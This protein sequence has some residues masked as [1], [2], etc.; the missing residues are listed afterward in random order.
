MTVTDRT[1]AVTDHWE[2]DLAGTWACRL[3][4][5]GVGELE[6]W[7][8][9]PLAAE[10]AVSLP[11][12][13]QEQ[14][15]GDEITLDTPWTGSVADRSLVE[16]DRYAPYREPGNISIPFWLQ[17]RVYYRGAAWY[18]R[19]IDVPAD[20]SDRSVVLHLERVHWESTVW[21]DERRVGQ[22]QSLT[23]PHTHDL[24]RLTPGRHLI[25]LRVDNRMVVDVG[26]NA[27]S[28]TDHTQGNWNGVVGSLTL[29]AVPAVR[30][31]RVRVFPDHA[32]RLVTAK[33]D[34]AAGPAGAGVG[35]VRVH[36]RGLGDDGAGTDPVVVAFDEDYGE[37]L[38][39]RGLTAAGG[40][41][42]VEVPLGPAARTWDEF[43][44]HLYELEV[45]IVTTV[46]GR[47]HRDRTTTVFGLR[48]IGTDGRHLLIN[49]RKSFIRGTLESCVFPLTGYPPTDVASW[50][51]IIDVCR[52]HGLNLLRFHS[53]CPPEAAF[54]AA[55][56]AGF[57]FQIEG[58]VWANQGAGLG[59]ARPVDD[60]VHTETG[61]ILDT[62]G[63]HPSFIMMAHGN[64]PG[65]RDAEFLTAWLQRWRAYDGRRLYT[66][67]AGWPVLE[68]N[69]F[70]ND[71]EPRAHRWGEGLSS[72]L[73]GTAPET[74][75][76]YADRVVRS[77]RPVISHEIGQWCVYP[78]FGEVDSYTGLMQPRNF[79]I[80]ADFLA[81]N[82][83]ADQAED[84]LRASGRL[85]VLCYKEEI[86]SA[87]RTEG[88]GGFHLLGLSDF[89]GQGT[90]LV[91]VVD[92]FWRSKAYCSPAE[93]AR[94]CG[95][96]VP[97]AR[98]PRRVLA[99]T[100]GIELE[101]QVAHFGAEPIRA[102]IAW[103]LRDPSGAE[104][105]SGVLVT[106]AA[107]E[108]GNHNRWGTTTLP[109]PAG[110]GEDTAPAQYS[111]ALAVQT[112][113][114]Q[115]FENDWDIWVMPEETD[116]STAVEHSIHV[117]DDPR[118]AIERAE[119]GADVLLQVRPADIG[120]DVALGFTTVF[121]NTAWTHG[122]APHTLG[123]L[124]D[125][126]HPVFAGFPTDGTTNW[127]WWELVQG[128]KA[129]LTDGLPEGL[130]PLVQP[131]D[132]WFEARPLGALLEARLG[133]GRIVVSSLNLEPGAERPAASQFRRSLLSYMSSAAF[134]PEHTLE[135]SQVLSLLR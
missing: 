48:D 110:E 7:F 27:H 69:D 21:V 61:R 23:T 35:S 75:T 60:F 132:T 84:F 58:P 78:D 73:N 123:L 15:I 131:I 134:A 16:D 17:P 77:D 105:S 114:G 102:D 113:E 50:R 2:L 116:P 97:L 26:P 29:A 28:V 82:G 39:A 43:S 42:D 99:A 103:S 117:T 40:H 55:D 37:H 65:G 81:Q 87:L 10:H 46:D 127:Q 57:Y 22:G 111:L 44:P 83:M 94:F 36:A 86:E 32:R 45:E 76:D 133:N 52:E 120:N 106:D 96:T 121:W 51:R 1:D 85:Q 122:Q 80:F 14:G 41:V 54:R 89:P 67:G 18:Q 12:S 104:V 135:S 128:A 72:R 79:G 63:N 66:S 53:W 56:E 98:L 30:I 49:G 100:G 25:T 9:S 70:D 88:F 33:I 13:I 4:P 129:M 3:D 125:P 126:G 19:E 59:E 68:V 91:G 101:A 109:V 34:L 31:S 130:R 71:F 20:W 38:D 8:R 5:Q 124:H 119:A 24:G 64:E 115:R 108:I 118:E 6:Q 93:F 74:C 95:P 107:I 112:P 90:A 47:E 11:G 62:F 92:P